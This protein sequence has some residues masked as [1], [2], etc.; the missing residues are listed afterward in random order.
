MYRLK[1]FF[2]VAFAFC[3]ALLSAQQSAL[4][5]H[6]ELPA[7]HKGEEVVTHLGYTLSYNEKHEQAN[8]VAYQ[9]TAEETEKAF[10]RSNKFKPDPDVATE[11][12]NN[13]DYKGSGYDRG[14]LAPA[15]DMS[16][17]REAMQESFYYSNMSPQVPAFN[18]GIWK[19]LE[20]QVRD[21]ARSNRAIYVVTGPV[22]ED[23]LPTIGPN[24]VSVPRYYY[25]VILDYT[26][27]DLKSI[28][29]VLPNEGSDK[30]LSAFAVSVD[31]V[32]RITH[33][34]FF[35]TLPDDVE[36]KVERMNCYACWN[37]RQA[38]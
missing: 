7:I 5:L 6:L 17:S 20:E 25:K 8:W 1:S 12:A 3:I 13:A 28:G 36:A 2:I 14:H 10:D 18:R 27:P 38:Q 21:W 23:G 33:L 37:L 34:D 35:P 30:P 22:L 31:E 24:G 19:E 15:A 4:I 32:E 16:W 11:S 26:K 9:L 29:F